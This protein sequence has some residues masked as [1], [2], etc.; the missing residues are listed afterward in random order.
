M[1][2][3]FRASDGYPCSVVRWP[4]LGTAKADVVFLNGIRS[5]AGWY[6]RSCAA[7]AGAGYDV[8]FL[9]RRGTGASEV[10]R[11]DAPYFR[12]LLDDVGEYLRA[13]RTANRPILLAGISWGGK[14]AAAV[15]Y[16]W[17]GTVDGVALLC[18][19]L[20][21]RVR[22]RFLEQVRMGF[23]RFL[24]PSRMFP[25]PLNEP[26]LFTASPE[27]RR[28]IA[29][30][31]RG[32]R[33]ASA[34]FF[35]ASFRLDIYLRRAVKQ[36]DMPVLLMLGGR[37]RIIDSARTKAFLAHAAPTIREYAGSEHTLEFEPAG[38]PFIAD[39]IAWA[40]ASLKVAGAAARPPR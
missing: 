37:D 16:R 12:R 24:A 31:E 19:G 5:H 38:H 17:P 20:K 36:L 40:D 11:G 7:I 22:P 4:A 6:G 33:E 30:D 3:T 15:P 27:W 2:E 14:L 13:I 35:A 10:A 8:H 23:S 34:R 39:F 25:I 21:P 18:P 9:E 29:E 32:Q 28:F 1:A 26:E